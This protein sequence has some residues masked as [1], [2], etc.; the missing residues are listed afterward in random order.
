[1]LKR[2]FALCAFGLVSF[3]PLLHAQDLFVLPGAG[4]TNGAVQAF[5]TNPL[6]TYREFNAGVGAFALLPNLNASKYFVVASATTN[7]IVETDGT[8][9]PSTVV[10]NLGTPATQ[11]LITPDGKLLAVLAGNV[12][13]YNTSTNSELVTGGVSQG[14]GITTTGMAAS[15]DSSAIF[16]VGSQGAGAGQLAAINTSTYAVTATLALSEAPTAVSVGPNSLVYVS[17]PNQIL[18][19]DPLTLQPTFNGAVS[20]SG[21]PGPLVFTPD[22]QYALGANQ[23][24]FGNSLI[25]ANLSSYTATS[26]SLGL[27]EITSLY[28]VGADTALALTDQGVYQ[29]AIST[30]ISVNPVQVSTGSGGVL[31]ITTTNDIPVGLETTVQ[32]AYFVSANTIYQYDPSSNTIV[33]QYPVASNVTPGAITYA[34]AAATEPS[35]SPTSL[36]TYGT[37]QTILPS[38]TSEPLVVEVLTADN[39]PLSGYNVQ[40]Q[41]SANGGTL[42]AT[43]AITGSN[44]YAVTYLT[45]SPNT[46][47]V[48]VTATAGSLSAN[49]TVNVS[50]TAQSATGPTLTIVGGQG[51]LLSSD[52]NTASGGADGSSLEVLATD[53]NGNPI[54]ALPVT[55]SVPSTEGTLEASGVE[56]GATQVVNTNANGVASVDFLSG[57]LPANDTQGFL[58][59]LVTATA[60]DTN[61]VTF[62]ITTVPLSPTPTINLLAPQVG[63]PITG[64]ELTVLPGAV[65]AQVASVTGIGIP[66]VALSLNNGNVDPSLFPTASC[67]APGGFVLTNSSGIAG[68]DVLFGPRTGSGTFTVSIGDTHSSAPLAFTVTTGAPS[69]VQITQGNNQSGSPGQTLPSA[70]LVN[71]TDSGGNIVPGATVNWQVV[72][73][74]TVTLKNVISVTDSNGNASALAVLGSIGGVAQVTATAGTG[75]ATFQLTVNIPSAGLQKVSGDQQ[76][77]LI[78]TA[79]PSPLTVKVVDSSGNGIAGAQVNFQVA[80]GVATLSSSSAITDST[81]QASTTVTAGSTAGTITITATAGS[82]SATF[83]LTAQPPGPANITIVNGASFD[84]NTGIS[85]GS[86]ATIRGIGILPG[87]TG[88]LPAANSSGELPTTFSG[89]TITFNGTPA[90]IYYVED[91]NGSDQVTV[92]VPFEVQPGSAVALTVTVASTGSAT[93]TIPVKPLA[94][95]IFTS[96]YGGKNYAVAVRPDGTYVS[97]TNPAQRGEDIELYVTGLG[98]ATPNIATGAFGVSDQVVAAPLLLGLNNGGVPLISAVYAPGLIG[99]Y[100]VSLQVPADT[101]TGPYQPIGLIAYDSSG[102]LYFAQ[103]SYIPIQ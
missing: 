7:S 60:S 86:I 71:V 94:P 19:V 38:A 85:P 51:Q 2:L 88:L 17:L 52:T 97:P 101:E 81:G 28:I 64:P 15:L 45:A 67:N 84:P 69:T 10:A 90:P 82:F 50:G 56:G 63:T 73:P 36:L 5:V 43:S 29:I 79:F 24:T 12:H 54:A 27:P 78:S 70:L 13:L 6:T 68:C 99:V 103:P 95:G 21:T 80:S 89:V 65:K 49:L 77:T 34:V 93:V 66:N 33:A 9:L 3:Y 92:Q 14:S 102:N 75:S 47:P 41:V 18:E 4:A 100:V 74:G 46:G 35:S 44:G 25:V 11:A 59:S 22:G 48:T 30:P 37:N 76:S 62:Y 16:V 96:A 53:A 57:M 72:T 23:S 91:T 1:M 87:V 26:P 83:T 98:E 55:F 58:Q 31:G 40:F 32:A 8:F 20:I 61:T 42:Y 39:V